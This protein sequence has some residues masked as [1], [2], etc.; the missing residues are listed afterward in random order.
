KDEDEDDV[1]NENEYEKLTKEI[2][3]NAVLRSVDNQNEEIKEKE[4]DEEKV[5]ENDG[6]ENDDD[7]VDSMEV[8]D[9]NEQMKEKEADKEKESDKNGNEPKVENEKE[10]QY[11]ADKVE[12]LKEIQDEHNHLTQDEFLDKEYDL[13][14]S[15]CD[16]LETKATQNLQKKKENGKYDEEK[17]FEAFAKTIKSEFKKDAEMKNMKDLEMAFFP[18][19][20]HEHHYLVVFNFLKGN[21]VKPA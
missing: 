8:D 3:E 1:N 14:D 10:K 9:Q 2:R 6:N 19:I 15:Q 12:K 4:N 16:E 7:I 5:S 13:T 20:D 18:I 11:E 17:Q 21:T